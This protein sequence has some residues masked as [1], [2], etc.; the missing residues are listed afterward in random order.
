M[1]PIGVPPAGAQES[2][3]LNMSVRRA[4]LV[5]GSGKW[6]TALLRRM[7]SSAEV[8]ESPMPTVAYSSRLRSFVVRRAGQHFEQ[9]TGHDHPA[10]RVADVFVRLEENSAVLSEPVEEDLQGRGTVG[11]GEEQVRI[12]PVRVC[13]EMPDADL[14]GRRGVVR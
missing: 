10:V 7:A 13:Q 5:A 4:P 11:V 2:G 3:S 9:P 6:P 14:F 12:D 8:E 1:V